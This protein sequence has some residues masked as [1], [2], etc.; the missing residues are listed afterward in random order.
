MKDVE[1]TAARISDGRDHPLEAG[2]SIV[3]D[4]DAGG[5]SQV[6]ADIRIHA[7]G[8][9]DDDGYAIFDE[10]SSQRAAFEKKFNLEGTRQDPVKRPDDQL[11]RTDG[12]RAHNLPLYASVSG[13]VT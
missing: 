10:T 1:Q 5:G 2:T 11:V 7:F 4:D 6:R 9:R 8:I 13:A 3:S 12:Q